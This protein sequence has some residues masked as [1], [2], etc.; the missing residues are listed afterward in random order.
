MP[1]GRPGKR[2]DAMFDNLRIG[3]RLMGLTGI[4]VVLL[5]L[6]GATGMIGMGRIQAGLK[7]VYEDR[8]VCL[9]QLAH[10][11]DNLQKMRT[12]VI[13]AAGTD[14]P[15]LAKSALDEIPAFDQAIDS[16][17]KQYYE[18]FLTPEEKTL[19]DRFAAEWSAYRGVRTHVVSLLAAGNRAEMQRVMSTDGAAS[20][21]AVTATNRALI[22]LQV[23]IAREEYERAGTTYQQSRLIAT[24]LCGFGL[25]LGGG[26][27]WAIGRSMTGPIAGMITVMG[28]LATGHTDVEVFGTGRRDEVGDIARSVAVFKQNAV[29][30]ARLESAQ[31]ETKRRAEDDRRSTMR[32]LADRFE[33]SVSSVADGV[34]AAARDMEGNAQTLSSLAQQVNTQAVT[35][36][37][38]AEQAAANV[39]TVAA[40]T[41]ELSSSVAEIGRQV[42]ESTRIAAHAVDEVA[43]TGAIVRQLSDAATR[44]GEVIELINGVAA[45]TNLLALNATIEAARAGEAG[46][47]FAVV[48]GEVKGLANQTARAT[49]EIAQQITAVQAE[50]ARAVAAISN[51]TGTIGHI[52]DIAAAIAAAVEQQGAATREIARNV[53]QAARGTHDVS[54]NI[55]GVSAAAAQAGTSAQKMLGASRDL[56]ADAASM[57]RT[58]TDFVATVRAG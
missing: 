51:V 34:A 17:W 8:A 58:V 11:L 29:E 24:L 42:V 44:I 1:N 40:A 13:S 52:S 41:E 36:A 47:G 2:G 55:A 20:F 22:D 21:N 23:R 6:L 28:R 56:T 12:R 7:T 50:T 19:A 45:Q 49:D 16:E 25:L 27:A 35:V 5:A 32:G 31:E 37:T 26:L 39:E 10:I 14:D 3:Q 33:H 46:K 4:M 57:R 15:A 53:E 30:K 43:A 9:G 38:A 18:T 54:S 48:A